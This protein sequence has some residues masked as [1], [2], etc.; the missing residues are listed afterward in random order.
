[1]YRFTFLN[2][3]IC[4]K[5]PIVKQK[6]EIFEDPG[7]E[8]I[9]LE[10]LGE[11]SSKLQ[12][13]SLIDLE[14]IQKVQDAFCM[15]SG[16]ASLIIKPDGTPI[17][18][19]SG[20]CRLCEAIRKT[21]VGLRNCRISDAAIGKMVK[22]GPIIQ[23]CLSGHLLDAGASI[24][25]DGQHLGSWLIGQVVLDGEVEEKML[26]YADEIGID[27]DT[28]RTLLSE[29]NRTT[30]DQF[31]NIGKF[32]YINAKYLSDIAHQKLLLTKEVKLRIEREKEITYLGNH[33]YLTGLYNRRFFEDELKRLDTERNFPISIIMGDVN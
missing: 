3:N 10:E 27:R 32:L 2:V 8:R 11:L 19:P 20:F 9:P 26:D 33:D 15:A 28:Y 22:E 17:T 24:I 21:E 12:F 4:V 1:M 6:V 23:P 29:V 13:K 18:K 25:V 16:M 7:E 30:P 31:E 14:E 5:I